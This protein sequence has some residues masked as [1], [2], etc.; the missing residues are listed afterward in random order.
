MRSA[1]VVGAVGAVSL[2]TL[3]AAVTE[4]ERAS[5]PGP[6]VREVL[7]RFLVQDPPGQI[8]L[9]TDG[10]AKARLAQRKRES[11]VEGVC[12]AA[13]PRD[14]ASAR[15]TESQGGPG[16][17]VVS[18]PVGKGRGAHRRLYSVRGVGSE[19]RVVDASPL[20]E[21]AEAALR[22]GELNEAVGLAETALKEEPDNDE[23]L[24]IVARV[25]A[26]LGDSGRAESALARARER[27][28]EGLGWRY[29]AFEVAVRLG[30]TTEAERAF[31][32]C[33][34]VVRGNQLDDGRCYAL[35]VNNARGSGSRVTL[36][37]L[38]DEALGRAPE[39]PALHAALGRLLIYSAERGDTLDPVIL[40][41][42]EGH[43]KTALPCVDR[44]SREDRAAT[45]HAL[46]TVTLELRHGA[47][48]A[49]AERALLSDPSV[50]DYR[51]T[52]TA[53]AEASL[54]E[55][56]RLNRR[57]LRDASVDLETEGKA[58]MLALVK[59]RAT[60]GGRQLPTYQAY[61]RA[62]VAVMQTGERLEVSLQDLPKPR[63]KT[64]EED[65][66]AAAFMVRA[67]YL[68]LYGQDAPTLSA[69]KVS[70]AGE[71]RELVFPFP[72]GM[73]RAQN[74]A[75]PDD[76]EIARLAPRVVARPLN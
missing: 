51:R 4:P 75:L 20:V 60:L 25:A 45:L 76:A 15:V 58:I 8:S 46:A 47:C 21:L 26:R 29:A 17:L 5:E 13:P 2:A 69:V 9:L 44:L 72:D 23:A 56:N 65:T 34:D 71:P 48:A 28:P 57:A 30:K 35:H 39:D 50:P 64:R 63:R 52:L 3:A 62:R 43:L 37:Q 42:A 41:E 38:L 66:V 53:C 40:S 18:Y 6:D 49:Y 24:G 54:L 16:R 11:V 12:P 32:A 22:E 36:K 10:S 68:A 33:V 55:A 27:S 7:R 73:G 1:W 59:D 61:S 31:E 70:F 14:P 74:S 67:V 19:A